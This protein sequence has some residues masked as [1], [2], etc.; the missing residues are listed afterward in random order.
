MKKTILMVVL[1]GASL[2]AAPCTVAPLSA[3]TAAGFNCTLDQFTF[4]EFFFGVISSSPGYNPLPASGIIVTPAFAPLSTG[5][6]LS[7][8]FSSQGFA[9]NGI[10]FVTYDI[11]YNIDPPPDI[12]I[13]TDDQLFTNT[14]IAPGTAD[15]ITKACVGGKW[16]IGPI[17]NAPG[18]IMLLH[19]FH[20]GTPFGNQ[21][22]NSIT[23]PGVHILGIDNFITL[24]ANGQS[25]SITGLTNGV[26]EATP[27][28]ASICLVLS[29]LALAALRRLRPKAS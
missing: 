12:I 6:R 20:N 14:P 10:D 15:V 18:N 13:E 8:N 21:L 27:E 28:P 4:K 11:R 3:Y 22:F 24:T 29:G 25:S 17:C 16:T 7:M 19:V 26:T 9:V 23:F 1:G 2:V 5:N